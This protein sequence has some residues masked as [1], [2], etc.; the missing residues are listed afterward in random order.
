MDGETPFTSGCFTGLHLSQEL[1][2]SLV[3]CE[4]RGSDRHHKPDLCA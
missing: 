4:L 1:R 2:K 3:L